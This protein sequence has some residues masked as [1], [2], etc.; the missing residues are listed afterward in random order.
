MKVAAVILAAGQGTR[1]ESDLPK[2][3]H[4]LA[5]KPLVAYAIE[6]ARA[7]AGARPVVVVGPGAD[8]VREAMGESATFVEQAERL[9]TG[10]AVLQ[11]REVLQG[12]SDL[13]LVTY[14]DMPLLTVET[15]RRLVEW[16][17]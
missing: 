17:R 16:Q 12:Q 4:P 1:M 7:L 6:T 2:V 3:L 10:H 13:V 8:P 11:A 5:G 14:A 9:G 15:L